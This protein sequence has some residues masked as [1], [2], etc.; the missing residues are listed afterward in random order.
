MLDSP[1]PER[2]VT[3]PLRLSRRTVLRAFVGAG[4]GVLLSAC[5]GDDFD[6]FAETRPAATAPPVEVDE[7]ATV[8]PSDQS[9]PEQAVDSARQEAAAPV[10]LPEPLVYILP[11]PVSQGETVLVV[12]EAPGAVS[13]SLWWQGQSLSLL[14]REDRFVGF[15]GIDANAQVGPRALGIGVWGP[16]GE[17]LLWQETVIEVVAFDWTVDDIRIDGP[18]AALLDPS[19]R[20][21]DEDARHPHQIGQSRQLHWLGVFDPPSD[22]QITA[23][24]GEQRSFNGGP[25]TEYHTGIDFGGETGSAIRAAN[26]GIV[27]W[28]GRTRRRGNGIIVD[29]G[30]GVFSGYYHLSE[31]LRTPGTVVEQGTLIGRM[32]ATG[33]ATG[34]HLHWEVVVRGVTVNP[35]PWLRLLEFPDPFQDLNPINALDSTN[36]A[37]S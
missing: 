9:S 35:L 28:A 10:V 30:A 33:L 18:N 34:P 25:I 29:H 17:Q 32:G 6:P 1:H 2:L 12:V 24:Y 23:L 27:S 20:R 4:A 19:V 11:S 31:V 14:Q 21:A 22:G 3:G 7:Q 15:F 16:D 37:R 13:A 5:G 26:S 36:L 8:Q